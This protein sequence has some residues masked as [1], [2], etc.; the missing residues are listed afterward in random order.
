MLNRKL[1]VP[2]FLRTTVPAGPPD[3]VGRS[4]VSWC[5]RW[6]P[7]A[8]RARSWW[9]CA[10]CGSSTRRWWPAGSENKPGRSSRSG[11][12]DAS[13]WTAGRERSWRRS[14]SCCPC[15]PERTERGQTG[16][17][18]MD[19]N[20]QRTCRWKQDWDFWEVH[21]ATSKEAL[22][23]PGPSDCLLLIQTPTGT[24]RILT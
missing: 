17:E 1:T 14:R 13:G 24:F 5:A 8:C 21:A 22:E 23:S 16:S 4:P 10:R 7:P 20:L 18:Q 19:Q 2:R 15:D 12:W 6:L 11:S 3:G 9:A